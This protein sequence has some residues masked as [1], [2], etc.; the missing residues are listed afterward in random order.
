VSSQGEAHQVCSPFSLPAHDCV[1]GHAWPGTFVSSALRLSPASVRPKPCSGVK[2]WVNCRCAHYCFVSCKL[3]LVFTNIN[4]SATQDPEQDDRVRV[5][6]TLSPAHVSS[7]L[8][9][10]SEPVFSGG[11]Q[12]QRCVSSAECWP[13]SALR[14][15]Y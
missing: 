10:Y 2:W 12:G 8:V 3:V 6:A 13:Q 4:I 11:K 14:G 1:Q 9:H 7:E 15:L 5:G